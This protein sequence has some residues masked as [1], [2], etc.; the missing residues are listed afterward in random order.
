MGL[1]A[2]I[3]GA[4]ARGFGGLLNSL[5]EPMVDPY[6]A[7]VVLLMHFEDVNNGTNFVDEK[8]HAITRVGNPLILTSN[9][10]YGSS[11]GHFSAGSSDYLSLAGHVDWTFPGDFTMEGTLQPDVTGTQRILGNY[12]SNSVGHWMFLLNAASTTPLWYINGAGTYAGNATT[13]TAG[14]KKKWCLQRI[15]SNCYLFLDGV[16]NGT[17]GSYSGTVGLSSNTLAIGATAGGG[18]YYSGT[19][20]EIRITK[21]IARY[22]ATGYV[23]RKTPFPNV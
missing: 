3:G 4:S 17:V 2:T 1:I 23:P 22:P 12:T 8:G 5:G 10:M 13:V 20:D 7:N 18:S 6:I 16:P 14:Q 19:L 21:G 11:S 15:G 9:P